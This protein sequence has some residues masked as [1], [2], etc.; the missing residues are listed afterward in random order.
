MNPRELNKMKKTK[1]SLA[2][3]WSENE[4]SEHNCKEHKLKGFITIEESSTGLL[5][6]IFDQLK[7]FPLSLSPGRYVSF[8]NLCPFCGYKPT[9]RVKECKKQS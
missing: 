5:T 9:S 1:K 8:I 3:E 4:W 2:I 7:S 6:S